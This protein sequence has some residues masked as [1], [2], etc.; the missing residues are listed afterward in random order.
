QLP[1]IATGGIMTATDAVNMLNAGATLIQLYTGY[2]Y[3]GP[4]LVK[5]IQK[6]FMN[7]EL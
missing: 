5:K 7:Y 1:I 3:Q 2:I 6:T 4:S